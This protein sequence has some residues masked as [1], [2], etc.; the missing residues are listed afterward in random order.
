MGLMMIIGLFTYRIILRALGITDYGVYSAVGG[1]VTMALLVMNTV[2]SAISRY[3]TVGLGKG[4]P[5][6]LKT[7][8]GTSL[9]VMGAFCL[10]I[11]LL[12]ETAGLWYLSHKMV[13]PPE[14]MGA[15]TVVLH[16]S[17]MVLVVNLMSI[18]FTADINA[19]EHMGAYAVIAILEAVL[20]LG[21]AAAVWFSPADKLVVY[22]WLLVGAALLSRGAYAAYALS[23][24]PE[25]RAPWRTDG[26]LVKEMGAFAGWNFLGSGANMLNTQ[27]I[28][29]L[30]NLFFGVGMNAARGVA[31]KVEQV[32]R[33]FATNIALALNPALTK[34]YVSGNRE[35]AF[36]LVC[37]GSKYY[38]WILWVLALPFFTDADTILSLWLGSV[39]PE[40]AFF[41]KLTL[42]C[43]VI[44]FTPG[45]LNVL[46]QAGGRIRRYYIWTSLVA[47]LAFPI[48][49]VA[50]RL[51]APAWVGYA[52]F[53]VIYIIKSIVMM[54]VA[55][56]ETG[57][58]LDDYWKK[59]LWPALAPGLMTL[60]VI[61]F[62]PEVLP[63]AWWRFLVTAALGAVSMATAIWQV[64]LTEGEKAY[65]RSKLP[66]LKK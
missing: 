16:T 24:F 33:Q 53:A 3:I 9:A 54:R 47:S 8:F 30:M 49:Y 20:K 50:Y 42:L 63:A 27:G 11:I 34:A 31:D 59:G 12:T 44:D 1:V 36:E 62:I 43:F 19:H 21:I 56:K 18:P 13:I 35:Y 51:G 17:L 61:S 52:A 38:F 7:I 64:G 65:V 32:V 5:E 14:R 66:W 10:I 48:T 23:R 28:N 15:A 40:A 25:S 45:T 26:L 58:P 29:Q 22:A 37:K 55:H 39:P 4:D 41:T 2:A 6:R 60:I 46:V 57:L